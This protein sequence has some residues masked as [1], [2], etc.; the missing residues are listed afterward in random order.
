MKIICKKKM[1]ERQ[2]AYDLWKE[3]KDSELLK[4]LELKEKKINKK[5]AKKNKLAKKSKKSC[6]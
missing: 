5:F 3:K 1:Y 2:E 4:A 6:S